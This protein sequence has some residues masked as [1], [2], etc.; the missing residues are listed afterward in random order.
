MMSGSDKFYSKYP[1]STEHPS[2]SRVDI[3]VKAGKAF[4]E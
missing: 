3:E 2:E 1:N 4:Y